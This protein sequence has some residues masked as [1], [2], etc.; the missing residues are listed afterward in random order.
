MNPISLS[1]MPKRIPSEPVDEN[2]KIA[3]SGN[4]NRRI[5]HGIL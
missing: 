1:T 4:D 5:Q 2:A 3:W